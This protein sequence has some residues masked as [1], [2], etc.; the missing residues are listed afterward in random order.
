MVNSAI[1]NIKIYSAFVP[2]DV[3][4]NEWSF[5]FTLGCF[6]S[7]LFFCFMEVLQHP[8]QPLYTDKD[9]FKTF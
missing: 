2:G 7:F 9:A 6:F 1:L 5:N 4:Y 3:V 8:D